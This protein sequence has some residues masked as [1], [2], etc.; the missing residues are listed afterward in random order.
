[1][2][3]EACVRSAQ[4]GDDV[5]GVFAGYFYEHDKARAALHQRDHVA[6]VRPAQQIALPMAGNGTVFG[7]GRSFADR[8][9]IDDLAAVMPMNTG[10]PRAADPP[11]GPKAMN[12]LLFQ[13]SARLNE[14]TS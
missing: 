10:V 13:R 14:Q 3:R 6:V 12:Q 1:M 9:G 2:S 4:S 5:S 8:N 11:L 7:F